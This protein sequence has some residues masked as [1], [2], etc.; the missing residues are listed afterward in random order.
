MPA[1]DGARRSETAHLL[2]TRETRWYARKG[3]AAFAY[4]PGFLE[5]AHSP[6]EVA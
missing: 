3:S 2:T 4:R 5:V 1:T 6:N